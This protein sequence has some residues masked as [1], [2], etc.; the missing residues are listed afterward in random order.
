MTDLKIPAGKK[1]KIEPKNQSEGILVNLQE[2]IR[3]KPYLSPQKS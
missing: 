2:I 3:D 1:N